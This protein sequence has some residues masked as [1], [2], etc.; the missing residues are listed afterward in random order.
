MSLQAERCELYA[1]INA[2]GQLLESM[3]CMALT[4][5]W[6]VWESE[7]C[8]QSWFRIFPSFSSS[9]KTLWTVERGHQAVSLLSTVYQAVWT[10][11]SLSQSVS[12]TWTSSHFDQSHP[13]NSSQDM[14]WSSSVPC[15]SNAY[16]HY[17]T[18]YPG[19]MPSTGFSSVERIM[20]QALAQPHLSAYALVQ[21]RI[22]SS[23]PVY[24]P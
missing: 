24:Y 22:S 21:E 6:I 3:S 9:C 14:C 5:L 17:T 16:M 23:P 4:Y 12:A 1:F 15:A 8:L 10:Y 11:R 20:C 13:T 19:A 2:S 7:I 18:S